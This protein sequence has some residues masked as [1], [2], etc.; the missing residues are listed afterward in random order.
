[1]KK[2]KMLGIMALTAL[3]LTGCQSTSDREAALEDQ[4][5]QLEQQVTNL[6]QAQNDS[7]SQDTVS[8]P[9]TAHDETSETHHNNNDKYSEDN[10]DTLSSTVNDVVKKAEKLTSGGTSNKNMDEFFT[11]QDEFHEIENRLD[12]YEDHIEYSLHQ[13]NLSHD[14]AR[15]A[16]YELEK[17]EDKLDNAEEKLEYAFGYDD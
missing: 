3:V 4:V 2:M 7:T 10:L 5:A 1:M 17:L 13:G 8:E 14:E 15:K 16:E 12:N 9:N 6:E 11:L